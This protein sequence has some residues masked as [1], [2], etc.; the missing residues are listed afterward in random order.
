MVHISKITTRRINK[1][2]DAGIDVGSTVK[3]KYMG[4]DKKG[5]M[6]FSIRDAE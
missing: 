2:T 5:R 1:V 4:L 3:V 6:D